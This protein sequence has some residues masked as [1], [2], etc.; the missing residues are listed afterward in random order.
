LYRLGHYPT[1]LLSYFTPNCI[2]IAALTTILAVANQT[3]AEQVL[4]VH[5]TLDRTFIFFAQKKYV[6]VWRFEERV[7]SDAQSIKFRLL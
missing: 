7:L 4:Y 2:Q 3:R 1:F 5:L 6:D